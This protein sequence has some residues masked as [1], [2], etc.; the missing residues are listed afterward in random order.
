LDDLYSSREHGRRC[1][2][3]K[4]SAGGRIVNNADRLAVTLRD[5]YGGLLVAA[6]ARILVAADTAADRYENASELDDAAELQF[7]TL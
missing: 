5:G 1:W 3:N 6:S 4:Y 2:S 7:I